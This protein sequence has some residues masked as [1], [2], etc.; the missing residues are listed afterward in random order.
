MWWEGDAV[1]YIDQ[2]LLPHRFESAAASTVAQVAEAISRMA[3]RGA[4]T[5]GVMGAYG[6]ALAAVTGESLSD[7]YDT[8]MGTRPTA[9]NL[10]VG[11]D[12]VMAAGQDA[13][14]MP[15]A[16]AILDAARMHDDAE[17]MAARDIAGT[18]PNC[19]RTAHAY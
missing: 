19:C 18:A 7:A 3:V 9:V 2:R 6:I 12:T 8:L 17:V 13:G 15:D 10:K 4:P 1:G 5:V 14:D 11:L 16:S